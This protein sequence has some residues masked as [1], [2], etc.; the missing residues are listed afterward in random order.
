MLVIG[1]CNRTV[2]GTVNTSCL[3]KCTECIVFTL[4]QTFYLFFIRKGSH[5]AWYIPTCWWKL[6]T[7]DSSKRF[8]IFSKFFN[9]S[10]FWIYLWAHFRMSMNCENVLISL[11]YFLNLF[12]FDNG[13][14]FLW[15]KMSNWQGNTGIQIYLHVK[16]SADH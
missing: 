8:C 3:C 9:T 10:L 11:C 2:K 14:E 7:S 5:V 15:L 6:L 13:G 1:Q 16:T 4:Q 12:S